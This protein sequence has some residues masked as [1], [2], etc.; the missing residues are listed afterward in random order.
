[1][2]RKSREKEEGEREYD[3]V[4]LCP[5][6]PSVHPLV[7]NTI[8]AL[9]AAKS[10]LERERWLVSIPKFSLRSQ[11]G[12]SPGLPAGFRNFSAI[13]YGSHKHTCKVHI[14]VLFV[15]TPS[16]GELATIQTFFLRHLMEMPAA[17]VGRDENIETWHP[18]L[19]LPFQRRKKKHANFP[20]A[21]ELAM[22]A[23]SDVA[24]FRRPVSTS[25]VPASC[26]LRWVGCW[27]CDQSSSLGPRVCSKIMPVTE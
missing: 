17:K 22:L 26:W 2:C 6:E 12:T 4:L 3:F 10:G 19:S 9:T 23:R 7:R 21:C 1:M 24:C 25:S 16:D 8:G 20:E 5:A 14:L 13:H 15:Q 27:S 18:I 11:A